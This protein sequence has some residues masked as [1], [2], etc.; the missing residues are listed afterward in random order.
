MGEHWRHLAN[1]T[2][3]FVCGG[4]AALCQVTLT[5][6]YDLLQSA[7][8]HMHRFVGD[9]QVSQITHCDSLLISEIADEILRQLGVHYEAE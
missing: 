5:A 4:D 7:C 8:S 6:C 3:P 9:L 2:E 1:T